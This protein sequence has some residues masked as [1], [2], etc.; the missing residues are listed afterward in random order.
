MVLSFYEDIQPQALFRHAGMVQGFTGGT[1][2]VCVCV[3][4]QWCLYVIQNNSV[5]GIHSW[6]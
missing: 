3:V 1:V 5:G 6:I 4:S 2:C